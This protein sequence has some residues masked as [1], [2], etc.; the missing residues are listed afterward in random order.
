MDDLRK[1]YLE[2]PE[3]MQQNVKIWNQTNIAFENG[4]RVIASTCDGQALRGNHFD[5]VVI[6]EFA[7]VDNR[8]AEDFMMNI[9]P[10]FASGETTKF[11]MVSTPK[12]GSVFDEMWDHHYPGFARVSMFYQPI[13]MDEV[14]EICAR[15]LDACIEVDRLPFCAEM[16]QIAKADVSLCRREIRQPH[17]ASV[18]KFPQEKQLPMEFL[19]PDLW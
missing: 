2:L 4:S 13:D 14:I 19:V 18:E 15:E 16:V 9:F 6:D 5:L 10:V 7:W 8:A 1:A 3:W 11:F 12:E 17:F